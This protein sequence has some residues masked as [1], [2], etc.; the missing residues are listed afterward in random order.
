MAIKI[1]TFHQ[2]STGKTGQVLASPHI[3]T[4]LSKVEDTLSLSIMA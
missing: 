3:E 2:R 1:V 4:K